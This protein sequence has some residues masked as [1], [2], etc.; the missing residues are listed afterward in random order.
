MV[1]SLVYPETRGFS[2]VVAWEVLETT[3]RETTL[4]RAISTLRDCFKRS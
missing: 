4:G 3:R 1:V 2:K